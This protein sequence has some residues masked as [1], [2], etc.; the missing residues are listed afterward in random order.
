MGCDYYVKPD[1]YYYF[2]QP[3]LRCYSCNKPVEGPRDRHI[4]CKND[5]GEVPV[6]LD[7]T[8]NPDSV[9]ER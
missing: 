3:G 4:S 1:K 8:G 2:P 5:N 6:V 7:W 9:R